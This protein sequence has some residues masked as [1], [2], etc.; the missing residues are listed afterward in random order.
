MLNQ[1][2]IKMKKTTE[3]LLL[4]AALLLAGC[5]GQPNPNDLAA[6]AGNGPVYIKIGTGWVR[7][8]H[9][10]G[11]QVEFVGLDIMHRPVDRFVSMRLEKD[12]EPVYGIVDRNGRSILPISYDNIQDYSEG[13]AAVQRDGR[14]SFVGKDGTPITE[15]TFANARGFHDGRAWTSEGFIN[16][17]GKVVI[18]EPY[19]LLA[20]DFSNGLSRISM[21]GKY[22]YMNTQGKVVV[23]PQFDLA[24]EF[25]EGL[26]WVFVN[27]KYGYINVKGGIV[28]E[29]QFDYAEDFSFGMARVMI[30][31]DYFCINKNGEDISSQSVD[32]HRLAQKKD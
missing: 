24:G 12:E 2:S 19:S 11:P 13:I 15:R 7:Y 20:S 1:K 31:E 17:A 27:G 5:G 22:G 28:I 25:R 4:M 14:W 30:G 26:A 18:G 32:L 23:V 21:D 29:P 6:D 3:K 16:M 10:F 8:D 9:V